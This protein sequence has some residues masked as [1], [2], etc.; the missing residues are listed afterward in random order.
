MVYLLSLFCY[1]ILEDDMM[2]KVIVLLIIM[3]LSGCSL[4]KEKEEEKELKMIDLTGVSFSEAK[5]YAENNQLKLTINEEYA[6]DVSKDTVISQN[7]NKDRLI[8]S[9]DEL[10]ITIS[11]G[12]VPI[13]VY[14]EN[15]VNELGGIPI[16]MYHGIYNKRNNETQ[17]TGGNYDKDG[18][19]RTVEA[20]KNDLEMYYQSGYRMIRLI[21]YIHGEI[22]VE[23]GKSPIV[24]TF[25]DGNKNNMNVTGLDDKGNII[26]DPNSA[27]GVLESFK[28]K[29]PDFKVTATFFLN[30]SLFNQKEYNEKILKWLIDN[31]YDIGNHTKNHIDFTKCDGTKAQ[32]EVGYM[33]NL[34]DTIILDRFINV[35]A[36]PFGSPYKKSHINFPLILSGIYKEFDYQTE[37]TLQVGWSYDRSPFHKQFDK[38]FLMRIRAWDNNGDTD[39]TSTFK[40]LE[41]NRYIS[42]GD[43]KT[44]VITNTD[45][46]NTDITDKK[47]IKY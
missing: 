29:Y 47:I 31:G 11:L 37:A 42:D 46:L 24:L 6:Y 38:T 5:D 44:I 27:V 12:P 14:Q 13:S 18:Y 15:N 1:N 9:G 28:K 16:M 8:K 7:I 21:D 17:Y 25:D 26:I 43:I 32:E 19:N 36:L 22:D 41:K 39:I 30:N 40:N 33:Y 45:N 35:M 4:S 34:L 20:F 3:L 2:K 23:L 10:V